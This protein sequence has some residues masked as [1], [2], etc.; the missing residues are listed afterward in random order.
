MTLKG[1]SAEHEGSPRPDRWGIDGELSAL[2]RR[3]SIDPGRDL[4]AATAVRS[5]DR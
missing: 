2:A 4:A 3:W 5:N 1:A